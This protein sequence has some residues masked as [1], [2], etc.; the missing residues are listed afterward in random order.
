VLSAANHL[1]SVK[2][3]VNGFVLC[4]ALGVK[5]RFESDDS[6]KMEALALKLQIAE[7]RELRPWSLDLREAHISP[8]TNSTLGMAQILSKT[9][10]DGF[11]FPYNIDWRG[12]YY[13]MTWGLTPGGNKLA[14]SLL[15][16]AKTSWFATSEYGVSGPDREKE[17]KRWIMLQLANAYGKADAGKTERERLDWVVGSEARIKEFVENGELFANDGPDLEFHAWWSEAKNPWLLLATAKE[18]LDI[19]GGKPGPSRL[20]IYIDGSAN[21][22]HHYAALARDRAAALLLNTVVPTEVDHALDRVYE[23]IRHRRADFNLELK[24]FRKVLHEEPYE[25]D[26]RNAKLEKWETKLK[27]TYNSFLEDLIEKERREIDSF[28]TGDLYQAILD[29]V[30]SRNSPRK[31]IKREA[32]RAKAS[33]K[34]GKLGLPISSELGGIDRGIVKKVLQRTFYGAGAGSKQR[35]VLK[36]VT[37]DA[38][39]YAGIKQFL[40]EDDAINQKSITKQL[41]A[42]V[43][44]DTAK[45]DRGMVWSWERVDAIAA[46]D[47]FR[48]SIWSRSRGQHRRLR[49]RREAFAVDLAQ[50]KAAASEPESVALACKMAGIA[51]L[52]L[53][54]QR[55]AASLIARHGDELPRSTLV[56]E[57]TALFQDWSSLGIP[58][59]VSVAASIQE[60]IERRGLDREAGEDA[61]PRGDSFSP[62]K[63]RMIFRAIA[64]GALEEVAGTDLGELHARSD[65]LRRGREEARLGRI[66]N[67]IDAVA[68]K[69]LGPLLEIMKDLKGISTQL[70]A[71]SRGSVDGGQKTLGRP[72]QWSTPTGLRVFQAYIATDEDHADGERLRKRGTHRFEVKGKAISDFDYTSPGALRA[73]KNGDEDSKHTDD[74]KKK[75]SKDNK[76]VNA[77]PPNVIH[78]LDASHLT[79]MLHDLHDN[80]IGA[81][82]AIH[83]C[84][85]IPPGYARF[86]QYVAQRC[87][88]DLYQRL[89]ADD[90]LENIWTSST[91]VM[92]LR[93]AHCEINSASFHPVWDERTDFSQQDFIG[94]FGE[95]PLAARTYHYYFAAR[96]RMLSA[97]Y[98][99]REGSLSWRNSGNAVAAALASSQSWLGRCEAPIAVN[100]AVGDHDLREILRA[101]FLFAL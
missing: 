36:L 75:K 77:L 49:T 27:A 11:Y 2:W 22:V 89:T 29:E 65:T 68:K 63:A 92:P 58:V 32:G 1:Q 5:R 38:E 17:E 26:E 96:Q 64:L 43:A 15:V 56:S 90:L 60:Q 10:K 80:G 86:A 70:C 88:Y 94:W 41:E 76:Q 100:A 45:A 21:V 40:Q 85:G 42:W 50:W 9:A 84:I 69:K 28:P 71:L 55:R 7:R 46:S 101:P 16:F 51:A 24:N 99:G 35:A 14:R 12:R 31:S 33:G 66:V 34:I 3:E 6:S 83:D 52:Q 23:E 95:F 82:G 47:W 73:V 74:G 39:R 87:F 81:F 13:P 79:L 72:A 18:Y 44:S 25:D 67:A 48:S 53:D 98:G 93:P 59:D 78:S 62:L 8:E 4:A 91:D 57:L 30:K 37:E 19:E 97:E 20:P 61:P 54:L